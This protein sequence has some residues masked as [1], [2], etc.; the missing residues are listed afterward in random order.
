MEVGASIAE[1]ANPHC[2]TPFQ[3][4]GSGR[5]FVFPISEAMEWNLPEHAKQKVVWLCSSCSEHMYVR[6]NRKKRVVQIVRK[7]G[8]NATAA[9][10][11]PHGYIQNRRRR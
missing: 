4:F 10:D 8:S 11:E 9:Y 3:R 5:L 6:L 2:K 1:C 7:H